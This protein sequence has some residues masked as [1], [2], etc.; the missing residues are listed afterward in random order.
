MQCEVVYLFLTSFYPFYSCDF[1]KGLHSDHAEIENSRT[2]I[3]VNN[4]V[5]IIA[6][7]QKKLSLEYSTYTSCKLYKTS[8]TN[9]ITYNYF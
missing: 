7:F 9:S 1:P 6:F 2:F 8:A 3:C 4:V 5:W